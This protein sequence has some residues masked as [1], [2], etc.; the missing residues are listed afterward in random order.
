FIGPNWIGALPFP[1]LPLREKTTYAAIVTDGLRG[2][3]GKAV[4]RAADFDAGVRGQRDVRQYAPR[5]AWMNADA[6]VAPHVVDDAAF[7]TSG[8]TSIMAKRRAAVYAQPPARTLA[9][10]VYDGPDAQ[11]TNDVYE[12]TYQGPNFQAG[13]PFNSGQ[14]PYQTGGGNLV[15]DGNGVPQM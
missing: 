14:P 7:T 11:G 8:A 15:F 10:L 4:R 12:A 2:V 6:A 1:G 5:V 13:A 3:D 9:G